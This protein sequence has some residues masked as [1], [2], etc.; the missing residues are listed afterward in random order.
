MDWI[1]ADPQSESP[2]AQRS[3]STRN[4]QSLKLALQQIRSALRRIQGSVHEHENELIAPVAASDVSGANS[5]LNERAE[6]LQQTVAGCVAVCVVELLEMIDVAQNDAKTFRIA[7]RAVHLARQRFVEVSSI[8][9]A[10]DRIANGLRLK[11][12]AKFQV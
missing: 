3:F 7:S 12:L 8:E 1:G 5:F 11:P 4:A 6:G 9:Q 2:S 10:G